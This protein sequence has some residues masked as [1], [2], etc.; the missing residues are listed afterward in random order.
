MSILARTTHEH[1]KS[2]FEKHGDN[3]TGSVSGAT[4]ASHGA[5]VEM[6]ERPGVMTF[7]P[8]VH[9]GGRNLASAAAD[10]VAKNQAAGSL[11]AQ[12]A[13]RSATRCDAVELQ[14]RRCCVSDA[15]ARA[16]SCARRAAAAA[17]D[18]GTACRVACVCVCG[19]A[20]AGARRAG[21]GGNKENALGDGTSLMR[22]PKSADMILLHMK[23]E[24][25]S[26]RGFLREVSAGRAGNDGPY[27]SPCRATGAGEVNSIKN[28]PMCV[29][30][31]PFAFPRL[32]SLS[33]MPWRCAR[34]TSV[35]TDPGET[36]TWRM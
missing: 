8:A 28:H 1:S 33:L 6:D 18:S 12:M 17:G 16:A 30:L 7:S 29:A 21:T 27:F 2:S 26:A 10:M 9:R 14:P 15:S 25:D 5:A 36:A 4:A 22:A 34:L 11:H 20:C 32:L 19:H 31:P 23:K 13:A 35:R 3:G 24:V